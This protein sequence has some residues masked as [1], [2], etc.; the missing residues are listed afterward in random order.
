MQ[1]SITIHDDNIHVASLTLMD[2]IFYRICNVD[3]FFP[4]QSCKQSVATLKYKNRKINL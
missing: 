2:F 3:A 4:N 1:M